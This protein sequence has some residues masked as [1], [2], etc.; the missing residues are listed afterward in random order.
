LI[1][2]RPVVPDAAGGFALDLPHGRVRMLPPDSLG[3]VFPGATMPALPWIAGVTL[4]TDD[5]TAALR[6]WLEGRSIPFRAAGNALL[7]QA[8]GATLRFR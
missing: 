2:G 5:A 7:V 1:A 4:G 3:A 6:S 8:G